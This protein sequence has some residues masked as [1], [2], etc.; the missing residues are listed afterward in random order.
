M[1]KQSFSLKLVTKPVT[2][3]DVSG[4]VKTYTLKELTGPQR[5]IYSSSFDVSM[6]MIKGKAQL[7]ATSIKTFSPIKFLAMCLYDDKDVQ[8]TAEVMHE[9]PGKTVDGIHKM[10]MKLSGLDEAGQEEAKNE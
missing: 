9:W 1:D 10:G 2:I 5:E 7:G 6:T 3:T 8:V 4:V